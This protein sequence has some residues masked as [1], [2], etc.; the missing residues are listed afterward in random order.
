MMQTADVY[1]LRCSLRV[2]EFGG[3]EVDDFM[4]IML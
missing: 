2:R 3:V 1:L 4:S